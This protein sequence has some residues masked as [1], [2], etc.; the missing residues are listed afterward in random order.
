MHFFELFAS[1]QSSVIESGV[2]RTGLKTILSD[3]FGDL[4][5]K[6]AILDESAATC[7][8]VLGP[9]KCWLPVTNQTSDFFKLF[10]I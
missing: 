2:V 3:I 6:V 9:Y 1:E 10:I 5:R 4:S 7:L 8:R